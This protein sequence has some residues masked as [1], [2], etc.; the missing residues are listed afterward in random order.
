MDFK[1][2]GIDCYISAMKDFMHLAEEKGLKGLSVEVMS[3]S[4]EPPSLPEEILLF[5]NTLNGYHEQNRTS[6]V[7]VYTVGDTS[8]GYADK[9]RNIVHSHEK[10]FE[11]CVPHMV[12]FHIKNTDSRFESTFG[13]SPPEQAKGI[14]DLNRIK[15]ILE[16][17]VSL[18]PAGEMTGYLELP[19]PKLG[20]DYSDP[21]LE[22]DLDDTIKEIKKVF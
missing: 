10:I 13:F 20:R 2:P 1:K 7:P 19:G 14:V 9:N 21:L 16:R 8:H 17:S 11:L 5:M 6:T 3:C 15:S 4:A 12:E 18:W 22:R